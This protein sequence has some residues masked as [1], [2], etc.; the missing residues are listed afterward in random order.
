MLLVWVGRLAEQL[1]ITLAA[2]QRV[3]A[4]AAED[5][6]RTAPTGNLVVSA[7]AVDVVVAMQ[8]AVNVGRVAAVR[9]LDA[10]GGSAAFRR[11]DFRL[12][13]SRSPSSR[14]TKR[15]SRHPSC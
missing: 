5:G 14:W 11:R 3:V 8:R 13:R 9:K 4:S 10:G 6:V 12:R 1:V 2:E 15:V 7:L